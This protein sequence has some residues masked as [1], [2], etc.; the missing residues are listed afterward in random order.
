[1]RPSRPSQ[2]EQQAAIALLQQQQPGVFPGSATTRLH[3]RYATLSL[4]YVSPQALPADLFCFH[5]EI[6][7]MQEF[8]DATAHGDFWRVR[9]PLTQDW[10]GRV[11][12]YFT[13]AAAASYLSG[14]ADNL[15]SGG[16]G[17]DPKPLTLT[18]YP[19]EGSTTAFFVGTCYGQRGRV[20]APM[21]MVTQEIELVSAQVP[22]VI[23]GVVAPT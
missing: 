5:W 13:R 15:R 17:A 11:Q 22:A 10:Q 21:A 19:G 14:M 2:S 4:D 23:L 3:G 12:G 9:L 16:I 20:L 7:V 8:A 18:L 1:M 6:E